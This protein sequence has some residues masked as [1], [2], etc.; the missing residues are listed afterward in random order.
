MKLTKI[1]SIAVLLSISS[2]IGQEDN[3]LGLLFNVSNTTLKVPNGDIFIGTGPNG[4]ISEGSDATGYDT[5]FMVGIY[6]LYAIEPLK[7]I[8]FE[9]FYDK[10]SSKGIDN[11]DFSAINLVALIDY[12]PFDLNLFLN[13]GVGVGYILNDVELQNS[14]QEQKDFDLFAKASLAYQFNKLGRI[15]LGTYFGVREVIDDFVTRS[16]YFIGIKLP[17]NQF[18]D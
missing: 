8:G 2:L 11:V 15:E 6:G 4:G 9:L 7:S 10:T 14:S 18:F 17:I 13:L 1:I 3:Q 16:K 5:N 12:E